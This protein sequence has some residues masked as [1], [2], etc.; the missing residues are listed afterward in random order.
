MQL[1]QTKVKRQIM[2][3]D[4]KSCFTNFYQNKAIELAKIEVPMMKLLI[5]MPPIQIRS[6]VILFLEKEFGWN[7][8]KN[9]LFKKGKTNGTGT[10]TG[11]CENCNNFQIVFKNTIDSEGY[12][13]RPEFSRLNHVGIDFDQ[14]ETPCMCSTHRASIVR[15]IML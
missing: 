10:V 13:V 8:G 1:S 5:K 7:K 3:L 12:T 14:Q 2:C 6:D 15:I 11:T 9:I 4:E